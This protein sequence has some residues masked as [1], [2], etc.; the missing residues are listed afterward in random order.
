M[1]AFLSAL[2]GFAGSFVPKLIELVQD[3]KDKAHELELLKYQAQLD[4]Q[5]ADAALEATIATASS[6]QFL[7]LQESYRA[8]I[9]ANEAVGNSWIVGFSASVRPVITYAFFA[10]Y[11][12]VKFAQFWLMVHPAFPWQDSVNYA[13]ALVAIW[14]EEDIALFSAVIAFWFGDRTLRAKK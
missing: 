3:G 7:A 4:A 11:A 13:S 9:A 12:M 5:R 14:G 6:A 10:L 2:L 8:D 1:I